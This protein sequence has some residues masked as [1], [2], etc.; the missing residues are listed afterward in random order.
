VSIKNYRNWL[1]WQQK[2]QPVSALTGKSAGWNR[3]L[4]TY[5]EAEQ[6]CLDNPGYQMGL[7]FSEDLPYIG[8]DLDSCIGPEGL[9]DWARDVILS[10][11]DCMVIDNKSVS[12]TGIKLVLRCSEKVKRGVKFIE[13]TAHG[14]HAPQVELFS[15]KEGS[16]GKY[17]ALTSPLFIDDEADE[18]NLAALSEIMGYD[19]T[20][21]ET[22]ESSDATSGETSPEKLKEMLD[23]LDIM[24]YDTRESWFKMLSAAHHATG[25]SEEGLEVF[26]AWSS[27]DEANYN[28]AHLQRDWDSLDTNTA[29]PITVAT[30]VREIAPE[31]RPRVEPSQDFEAIAAPKSTS[32]LLGWLLNETTRN[33]SKV[34]EQ[35]AVDREGE[36]I[37]YVADWDCWIIYD[38]TKWI[39]DSKGSRIHQHVKEYITS[40]QARIPDNGDSEQAAKAMG[41]TSQLLNYNQTM[42]V[43]K[44]AR[45]ERGLM[46]TLTQMGDKPNL[47]NFRNGT[48]D[49][50]RDEF[51][52]HQAEDYIFY[53]CEADY[54]ADQEATL[55]NR[56]IGEIFDGDTELIG[57]VRR[58][59]GYSISG[60]TSDPVFN[61]FYGDG[62]NG[63]S[64]VVGAVSGL[65]G[66]YSRDLPSELFNKQKDLHPT[67]LAT[68]RGARLAVVAEMESDVQL[69]EA[70]IKKVTSSDMIEARRMRE[71]P[72]S[73]KPSHTSVLCTNHLPTV[74]GS[75]RGI[76]RRL[77]CVPFEVDLTDRKDATIPDRLTH[78]YAGIANWLIQGYREYKEQGI[79]TCKAVEDATAAYREGEDEFQRMFEDLFTASEESYLPVVDA[80]QVYA[81]N[82]GRLGRKKFVSEME[83]IGFEAKRHRVNG[84][85]VHSFKGLRLVMTEFGG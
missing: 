10:L 5:A 54:V 8:V 82:G 25:G 18:A 28:E 75:D 72:W 2:H 61:I 43:V 73:F 62:A 77:K 71:D 68:L 56:V 74:R 69:A 39:R 30:I 24:N 59:L 44:Q 58:L 42:G 11:V 26:K 66:E 80:L 53:T 36:V 79:G 9:E 19:V 23:K 51:R 49:L 22:L 27:G 40:L 52:G 6:F 4:A 60:D 13:A 45:G 47:L 3:N 21:F 57:Y 16:A 48:Y 34:V 67:Y 76:W 41:W 32:R 84:T 70:T 31:D 46:I 78:E 33:H 55:W 38:G 81:A 85:Q 65:L 83:R 17:F 37:K 12:G 64:T 7:C 50:E 1:V 63:K 35:L 14:D 29:R 15:A 20:A